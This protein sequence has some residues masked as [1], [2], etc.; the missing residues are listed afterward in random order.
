M[1]RRV[2]KRDTEETQ[3]AEETQNEERR[4]KNRT[5]AEGRMKNTVPKKR[6]S[7][8]FI[9]RSAFCVSSSFR[10]SPFFILRSAFLPVRGTATPGRRPNSASPSVPIF[11]APGLRRG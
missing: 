2:R 7:P 6:R 11:P 9:L 10:G 8:F 5:G 1:R 3:K 4:M